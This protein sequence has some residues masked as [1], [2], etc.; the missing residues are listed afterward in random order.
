MN[1]LQDIFN[2]AYFGLASQGFAL[3][4]FSGGGPCLYRGPN[5]LKCAIGHCIPDDR[6]NPKIEGLCVTLDVLDLLDLSDYVDVEDLQDLQWCHDEAKG[7]E[8]M[9]LNLYDFA[10]DHDL[11]IP[12]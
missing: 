3:S 9:K 10:S 4:S 1:T 12:S 8:A 7:A 11:T 6:Y 2:R 5:G